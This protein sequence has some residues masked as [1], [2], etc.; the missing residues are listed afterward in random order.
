MQ[1]LK[2]QLNNNA[3]PRRCLS[4]FGIF[5]VSNYCCSDFSNGQNRVYGHSCYP[6]EQGFLH[7]VTF[8]SVYARRNEAPTTPPPALAE[9]PPRPS[10]RPG[11]QVGSGRSVQQ[12]TPG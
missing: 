2:I 5:A 4:R 1:L 6:G 3:S 9:C 11:K 12:I 8:R 7:F 10:V